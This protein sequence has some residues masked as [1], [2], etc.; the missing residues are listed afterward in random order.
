[1]PSDRSYLVFPLYPLLL[2]YETMKKFS[3]TFETRA[4]GSIGNFQHSHVYVTMHQS[5]FSQSEVSYDAMKK[6][7]AKGLE[8]RFPV[9]ILEVTEKVAA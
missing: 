9:K 5:S 7:H 1:M 2:E 6:L 8:T 3:V 4:R